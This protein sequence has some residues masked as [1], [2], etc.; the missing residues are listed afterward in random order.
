M[1]TLGNQSS[2]WIRDGVTCTKSDELRLLGIVVFAIYHGNKRSYI[3]HYIPAGLK[4]S[5]S[6]SI[7]HSRYTSLTTWSPDGRVV[8]EIARDTCLFILICC[9]HS[10]YIHTSI[11]LHL[12]A[13]RACISRLV[14]G[15]SEDH[16][17]QIRVNHNCSHDQCHIPGYGRS[18]DRDQDST[19]TVHAIAAWLI[20]KC[21]S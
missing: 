20:C 8:G 21:R 14:K 12:Q 3:R 13:D 9:T 2:Q 10:I 5:R 15:E 11:I 17:A 18:R 4:N 6:S 7:C 16:R 1:G 19:I